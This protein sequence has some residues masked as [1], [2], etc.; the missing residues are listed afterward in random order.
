MTLGIRP[1]GI[2]CLRYPFVRI[3]V[4]EDALGNAKANLAFLLQASSHP[5]KTSTSR[6]TRVL[7]AMMVES[8]SHKIALK[9]RLS[10]GRMVLSNNTRSH[11]SGQWRET[12]TGG[13][14]RTRVREAPEI[15]ARRR[16]RVRLRRLI[17]V[18]YLRV[19]QEKLLDRWTRKNFAGKA[20]TS[21][22]RAQFYPFLSVFMLCTPTT[23]KTVIIISSDVRTIKISAFESFAKILTNVPNGPT[24]SSSNTIARVARANCAN[25]A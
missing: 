14:R 5:E 17:V 2:L 20:D 11:T 7:S 6:R 3:W 18:G 12:D 24:D 1:P 19:G 13:N 4:N 22:N 8:E 9:C 23:E 25:F 21:D 16:V 15:D 10:R